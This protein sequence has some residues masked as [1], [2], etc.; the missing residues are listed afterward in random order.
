MMFSHSQEQVLIAGTLNRLLLD[1]YPFIERLRVTRV[2]PG[3]GDDPWA[4]LSELGITAM[5][6]PEAFEGLGGGAE[7][8]MVMMEQI[9]RHL[10]VAPVLTSAILG[11]AA[12][13]C[14]A[15]NAQ[16]VQWLPALASG[17]RRV[18]LAIDEPNCFGSSDVLST[19][20]WQTSH[21]TTLCGHKSLV[22]FAQSV[23]DIIV[24]AQCGSDWGLYRVECRSET[25]KCLGYRTHDGAAA[26]DL[27]FDNTP[28]ERLGQ[29]K[30]DVAAIR[31]LWDLGASM[32]CAEALGCMDAIY[33][34]TR[35]HLLVR[36]QF[37]VPLASF[38][39]LRHRLV[40]MH[41]ACELARSITCGAIWSMDYAS[42]MARRGGQCQGVDWGAWY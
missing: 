30:S 27:I 25:V 12:I 16:C 17:E 34:Q 19:V 8:A 21:G 14:A 9:G 5:M 18:S 3:F 15:S 37:G 28:A 10:L 2:S 23:D 40:D 22:P 1:V 4:S 33:R 20:A 29:G 42:P 31:Y 13:A 36:E 11:T 26:A 7:D 41:I 32:V 38:Q 6:V 35:D 39:V 24:A